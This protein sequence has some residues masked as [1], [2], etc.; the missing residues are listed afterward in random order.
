MLI[1]PAHMHKQF[2]TGETVTVFKDDQQINRFYMIPGFP[3][4]RR[5][6]NKNPVFQLIKFNFSDEAR[7]DD[8]ELA[9]GG[10]Y[11]VFDAELL[12]KPEHQKE[13][14]EELQR[15]VDQE[16]ERLEMKDDRCAS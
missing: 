15:Y 4:I 10:G 2:P 1:L 8:P 6:P 14:E 16:W 9:R 7:E 5:D 13:V 12:V 11:M 3:T